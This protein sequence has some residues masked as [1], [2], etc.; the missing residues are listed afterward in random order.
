[1]SVLGINISEASVSDYVFQ[2]NG[3]M[4]RAAYGNIIKKM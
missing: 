3:N 1:M 4:F 2:A